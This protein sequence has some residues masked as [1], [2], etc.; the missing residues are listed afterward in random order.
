ME[1][2]L[3]AADVDRGAGEWTIG[4][5]LKSSGCGRAVRVSDPCSPTTTPVVGDPT[6]EPAIYK[7]E[8]FGVDSV[9]GR[10][11]RCAVEEDLSQN[12]AML[13][14]CEE[15]AIA[16]VFENGIVPGWESPHLLHADVPTVPIGVTVDETV[17]AVLDAFWD[18]AAGP[19]LLHLGIGSAAQLAKE[20]ML[21]LKATGVVCV[22]SPGYSAG[23]VAATDA[24]D[25]NIGPVQSLQSYN[26]RTNRTEIQSNE[27]VGIEFDPCWAV[28]AETTAPTGT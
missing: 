14:A 7:V 10:N 27:I 15:R 18:V 4:Y 2:L 9:V 28:R 12:E 5:D 22:V 24:V 26:T 3:E 20:T 23:L 25:I 1:G 11:T 21:M 8:P 16:H 6:A 17:V 19:P 13:K